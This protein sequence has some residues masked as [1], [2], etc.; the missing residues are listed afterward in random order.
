MA[1]KNF[2]FQLFFFSEIF[3]IN[4]FTEKIPKSDDDE[5]FVKNFISQSKEWENFK[6][7]TCANVFKPA[8]QKLIFGRM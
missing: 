3:Q 5:K 6:K 8:N 7:L 4:Q 2:V 1:L